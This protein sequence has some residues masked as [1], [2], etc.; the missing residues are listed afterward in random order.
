MMELK[1]L[2]EKHD[3]AYEKGQ[4]VRE[5]ASNDMLFYWVTQWDDNLSSDVELSYRGEFNII[6]KAGR[7]ITSDLNNNPVQVK[8]DSKDE[9]KEENADIIEGIYR[10]SDR[11]NDSIESYSN[12]QNETVVCGVGA[13]VLYTDYESD[14]NGS[15][16]QKVK[17]RPIYEANAN[18][19]WDSNAKKL[20]KSDADYVS[21][22]HAYSEEGYKNLVKALTGEEIDNINPSSFATPD[23]DYFFQWIESYNK[24]YVVEF[25]EKT[26]ISDVLYKIES[27]YGE[28]IQYR[29]SD[30][31]QP[32]EELV[33]AGYEILEEKKIKRW[34]VKQYIASGEKILCES[35]IYGQNIPVV[36]V[37][38]E[39]SYIDGEEWYEGI[40]R[41]AKDPQRLRNFQLS[42][43]ADITSRSPRNKPIF[44]KEQIAGYEWMYNVSGAENNFPYYLINSTTH[45][46]EP[47]PLQP[48]MMPDQQI[49][50]SLSA[51][52]DLSRQAVEDVANPGLP[53]NIADPDLS[54]KAVIALQNRMD[55]QSMIYQNN[56]KHAKRR[57]GE[58]FVGMICEMY[59]TPVNINIELPDGRRKKVKLMDFVLDQETGIYKTINDIYCQEF[60]VF[61]D[62]GPSY[63][64]QK[65]ETIEKISEMIG[66]LPAGDPTRDLLINKLLSMM[67]GTDFSDER[68]YF[69][70]K[71]IIQGVKKPETEE[72]IRM[73]EEV[74]QAQAQQEDPAM[75][76]AEAEA[77]AR[78]MEGQA[79][80]QGKQ[81]DAIENEIKMYK[82]QT[83]R[84][85]LM[86]NAAEAGVK[87]ENTQADTEGKRI[88][89]NA[90]KI[91]NAIKINPLR[92]RIFNS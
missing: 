69:K 87:I 14:R 29:E 77:E 28:E 8:F 27:P 79:A 85:K 18:V 17:R 32:I 34:E 2:K 3:K 43:L 59:D 82:A 24:I 55:M 72:E 70:N 35:V 41:L 84:D 21:I 44:T 57:D 1:E 88:A 78:L 50:P 5:R 91:D 80:L 40:T 62:I 64:S 68:E 52:I 33:N 16:K 51:S 73:L 45:N 46:G 61:A 75:M 38:G 86:I 30:F 25:Y 65:Q 26:L 22:L 71:L 49:P 9:E 47:L 92:A 83:E 42:Y 60:D 36:P 67:S 63:T 10:A 53:Q 19:F 81:N 7:Q 13:W 66:I 15:F 48:S 4:V 37:Y 56:V 12:A 58:I 39:R 90:A 74:Q 6:R 11:E 76:V 89:N 23:N 54:G 31:E 20:D